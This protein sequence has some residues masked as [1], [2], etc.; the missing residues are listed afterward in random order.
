MK[1]C[2]VFLCLCGSVS[3]ANNR[4]LRDSSSSKYR[5]PKCESEN[6]F[7]CTIDSQCLPRTDLCTRDNSDNLCLRKSYGNCNY[8]S[9][10]GKF[11]VYKY[12]TPLDSFFGSSS[13]R[14][15]IGDILDY[16]SR[17]LNK[18][19]EHQFIVYRGL[20]Y[21]YGTYGAR[22][23][24]PNDNDNY[25]YRR[26]GGRSITSTNYVGDSSCTYEQVS[27]FLK[28][29]SSS[30]YRLC[31]HDCQDFV[32]GLK[33]H[34]KNDCQMRGQIDSDWK[35]SSPSDDEF[36]EYIFSISGD[37]TCNTTL[38]LSSS[39]SPQ[40]SVPFIQFVAAIVFAGSFAIVF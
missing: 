5:T 9:A 3:F 33:T 10:N 22:I 18:K 14:G 38:D 25:E 13:R 23:Q 32:K 4:E 35:R 19:G 34:L 27:K 29:W 30:D 39:G 11:E 26:P 17:C 7:Y 15:I 8:N 1:V 2:L 21:E 12:S 6:G 28:T 24:D 40:Q 20:M 16:T 31:S 37:G 36:A